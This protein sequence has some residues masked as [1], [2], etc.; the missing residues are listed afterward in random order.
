MTKTT[1]NVLVGAVI[2]L[3]AGIGVGLLAYYRTSGSARIP[4]GLPDELRYVPA[5]AE[6]VAYA[7]VKRVMGSD[8]RREV[9]RSSAGPR[10]GRDTMHEI[11]GIDLETQ[12]SH[13]VAYLEKVGGESASAQAVQPMQ[14]RNDGPPRGLLIAQGTFEQGTIE[15][16]LREHGSTFDEYHGKRI[17][18]HA[19]RALDAD[20]R[21]GKDRRN[22]DADT[23]IAFLE[24]HLIALGDADLVRAAIDTGG[25]ASPA[26][27]ITSNA[28]VMKLVRDAA[29]ETAWVVGHFDAVTRR[30]GLPDAIR[31]QVPPLRMIA[32]KAHINGGLRATVLAETAD[33]AAADQVRDVVRG[34]VSLI[35]LQ[36]GAKPEFQEVVKSIELGGSGSTV[37]LSFGMTA[38]AFRA[39]LPPHSEQSPAD[40]P[41]RR[42]R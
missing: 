26:T 27:N 20:N 10:R 15:Q 36:A 28:D 31:Q 22:V 23:A 6:L 41:A 7:D 37:R 16:V 5:T 39:I 19:W 12:V 30:I 9:E 18:M 11:A 24:P 32:A 4:A 34:F 21:A 13:V 42:P 1:R 14:P 33:Q 40:S 29:G 35:R 17:A 38:E 25:N 3:V 8:L 2:L